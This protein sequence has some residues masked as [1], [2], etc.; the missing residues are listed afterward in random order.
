MDGGDDC[1]PMWICF[2]P[3]YCI[4]TIVTT[5][6]LLCIF[7]NNKRET[8][9]ERQGGRHR[10][11]ERD[12]QRERKQE[13]KGD[14]ER[15]KGRETQ[16]EQSERDRG[17][18]ETGEGQREKDRDRQRDSGRDTERDTHREGDTE[19]RQR[20]R[21]SQFWNERDQGCVPWTIRQGC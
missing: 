9:R 5:V 17:K 16:R 7:Y 4:L 1:R 15:Q 18:R 6:N 21:T 12:K 8:E 2:T 11:T 14:R 13:R 3:L 20:A 10:K 19:K